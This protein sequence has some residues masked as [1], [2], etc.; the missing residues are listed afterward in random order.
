MGADVDQAPSA[1][2]V[3]LG[4]GP[5]QHP[6]LER[7]LLP[8]RQRLRPA[9]AGPVVQPG[10]SLGVVADHR[11]AERLALHPRKPGGLGTREA[12]ER[13]SNRHKA[14]GGAAVRLVSC[15]ATELGGGQILADGERGHGGPPGPS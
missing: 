14:H 8:G 9:R 15:Q 10:R 2:P 6:G 5:A 7:G 4:V 1:D 11:V 3:P 12:V 13:M